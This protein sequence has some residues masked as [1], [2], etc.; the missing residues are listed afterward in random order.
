MHWVARNVIRICFLIAAA[1]VNAQSAGAQTQI[2]A[3]GTS[4][5]NG[6]GVERD[7]AFPAL[8]EQALRQKGYNVTVRNEGV[9][10]DTAAGGL[11][12]VDRAVPSGSALAIVEFGVNEMIGQRGS[13][14]DIRP[15]LEGIAS[16]LHA[17]G[18]K[19]IFLARRGTGKF[20]KGLGGAVIDIVLKDHVDPGSQHPDA[21]GHQIAAQRILPAVMSALGK[22]K[23]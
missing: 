6:F 4:F 23:R 13:I 11:S 21:V 15:S 9:N 8:L 20:E 12:R 3:F 19:T 5:T 18:V 14:S 7:A 1:S 22:P 16:N 2:V 17:R 10:G